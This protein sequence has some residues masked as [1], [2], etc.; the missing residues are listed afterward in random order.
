MEVTS[1]FGQLSTGKQC[2]SNI[3]FPFKTGI[4]KRQCSC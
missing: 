2:E 3:T 1:I 4:R